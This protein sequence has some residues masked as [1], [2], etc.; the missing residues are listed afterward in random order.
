MLCLSSVSRKAA[1]FAGLG[2]PPTGVENTQVLPTVNFQSIHASVGF[3]CREDGL[4]GLARI[5]LGRDR[6]LGGLGALIAALSLDGRLRRGLASGWRQ[7]AVEQFSHG[8]AAGRG[9]A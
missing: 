6:V 4:G 7:V 9:D 3:S 8:D 1:G 5:G 2:W